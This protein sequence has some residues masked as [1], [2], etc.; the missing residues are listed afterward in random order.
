MII[1]KVLV[2]NCGSSSV[3]YKLFNTDENIVLAHGL[4]ERIGGAA[5]TLF[6]KAKEKEVRQEKALSGHQEAIEFIL[7]ALV[8]HEYGVIKDLSEIQAVG[9]RVVHGG[10]HFQQ[11]IVV[12]EGV[13][14]LLEECSKLA[15]LHNPPN[16]AGIKICRSLIHHAVQVAVFDTAFHQT[17]PAYAYLY[18]IPYEF[19]QKY[20][21]RKYGFHGISH[22]YVSQRAAE[23]IGAKVEDLRI[24]TCHLGNGA[25]LCAVKG[26]KS[27]DTTMGLTPL[28]GVIMGTRCGDIDPAIINFLVEREGLSPA[29][30]LEV[31][32]KKS[33]VLGISGLSSD[34]RDLQLAADEGHY[35]ARLALDMFI[36]SVSKNI[37]ALTA[38]LGGIDALVFT[39]GIGENSPLIRAG[40]CAR[41]EYMGI[42][43]DEHKNSIKGKEM[44]IS[45]PASNVR[46]LVIPTDE[47]KMIS[48]EI[49]SAVLVYYGKKNFYSNH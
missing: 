16:I 35:R 28:A 46:V 10:E 47:E 14:D 42:S 44:E 22:K 1:I 41:L 19:Y 25:S 39:A 3:K 26:G 20:G 49:R 18:A 5:S 38:A 23:L 37:S 33:G 36:Y 34:F 24:I 2:L 12:D 29:E 4:V 31:L 45:D 17:M 48:E 13:L 6:Y 40:I 7:N 43:I 9:H 11:P 27:I 30:V 15:P 21:I 8:H 32:N